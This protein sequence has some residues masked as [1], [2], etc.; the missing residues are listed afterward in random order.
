MGYF[1]PA[2]S[3]AHNLALGFGIDSESTVALT[4]WAG[5][6]GQPFPYALVMILRSLGPSLICL[7]RCLVSRY[8]LT[9]D[10]LNSTAC[11]GTWQTPWEIGYYWEA[12]WPNCA[13][14]PAK[15]CLKCH[16][17]VL[18][19]WKSCRASGSDWWDAWIHQWKRTSWGMVIFRSFLF[20]ENFLSTTGQMLVH[21]ITG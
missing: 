3:S 14:E 21:S 16:R 6:M 1:P 17:E 20:L 9:N 7:S 15:V 4:V 10:L 13:N 11:S 8:F 5:F 19:L 18:S 2:V 12:N